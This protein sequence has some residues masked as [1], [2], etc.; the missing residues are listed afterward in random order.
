MNLSLGY[1]DVVYPFGNQARAV[2]KGHTYDGRVRIKYLDD[3][4]SDFGWYHLLLFRSGY[5]REIDAENLYDRPMRGVPMKLLEFDYVTLNYQ[6]TVH[7]LNKWSD[8]ITR[9]GRSLG[10]RSF[11]F[12]H[13]YEKVKDRPF[14]KNCMRG[15]E[16]AKPQS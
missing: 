13:D 5:Q 4:I 7:L 16:D 2:I 3:C 10:Y 6:Q 15:V 1:G 9:C 11:L 8:N 12:S 14:C